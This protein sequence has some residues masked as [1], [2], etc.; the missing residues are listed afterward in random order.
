MECVCHPCPTLT[1][2]A[3]VIRPPRIWMVGRFSSCYLVVMILPT[4]FAIVVA[5]EVGAFGCPV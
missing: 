2:W 3:S 1:C 5:A 4:A